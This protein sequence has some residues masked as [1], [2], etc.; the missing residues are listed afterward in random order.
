MPSFLYE[1]KDRSGRP[2][3]GRV[4]AETLSA[5]R[6]RLQQQGYSEVRFHTDVQSETQA[7]AEGH[8]VADGVTPEQE[9]RARK[10]GVS[11]PAALLRAYIG[12][13]V[14]WLPLCAWAAWSLYVGAPYSIGAWVSFV[15]AGLSLLFPVWAALPAVLY[16]Q[17]LDARSWNRW[18][19]V[20]AISRRIENLSRWLPLQPALIDATFS[21]AAAL[22]A[23]GDITEA[24]VVASGYSTQIQPRHVYLS[25]LNKIYTA[26][27]AWN[28]LAKN[29]AS[30]VS[31][32]HRG[33]SEIIDYAI[34]LVW[35]LNQ[36]SEA[37]VLLD[38]VRKNE[39][40]PLA[41]GNFDFA[42]GLVALA[43]NRHGQADALLSQA[44]AT[45]S[46]ASKRP[47]M[48]ALIDLI[49]AHRV[50]CLA[51]LGRKPEAARLLRTVLPRL[52]AFG[53]LDLVRRCA[54]AT[55]GG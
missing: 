43:R 34:T 46:Q 1:A 53:E 23:K 35:R 48:D 15:F 10:N 39:M 29:Q 11:F 5:A 20:M 25:R 50:L 37:A 28:D 16:A 6:H 51:A 22:A 7:R 30:A 13:A 4:Q 8:R 52:K 24:M 49:Q 45:L 26:A 19:E 21:R 18:D 47:T 36:P 38:E 9:L 31:L 42:D 3:T 44:I 40:S 27:R 54:A 33:T 14:L 55:V 12:N 32:S 2:Q 17:L 41:R